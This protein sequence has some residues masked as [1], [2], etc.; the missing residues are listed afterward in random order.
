[1]K[2]RSSYENILDVESD[3]RSGYSHHPKNVGT[4]PGKTA[5]QRVNASDPC[6]LSSFATEISNES[7]D[8]TLG[9]NSLDS[10]IPGESLSC[11]I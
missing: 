3:I 1:M 4:V 7:P 6:I 11:G 9:N 8:H 2:R 10:G 5:Y